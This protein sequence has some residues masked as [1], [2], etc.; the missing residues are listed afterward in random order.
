MSDT[1]TVT[2]V[3]RDEISAIAKTEFPGGGVMF[4]RLTNCCGASAKGVEW[5]THVACRACYAELDPEM[6]AAWDSIEDL[7]RWVPEAAEWGG[8]F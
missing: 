4:S 5:G 2:V 7:I 1:I 6:G 3:G 8:P